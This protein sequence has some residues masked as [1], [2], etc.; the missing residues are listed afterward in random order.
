M[1]GEGDDFIDVKV[2]ECDTE[3][4]YGTY[5]EHGPVYNIYV[6]READ[7]AELKTEISL[8]RGLSHR[9]FDVWCNGRLRRY[10]EKVKHCIDEYCSTFLIYFPD[11]LY[12]GECVLFE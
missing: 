12:Q 3:D 1:E 7:I 10:N 6:T 2:R 4:E 5:P 11:P 9:K 8:H